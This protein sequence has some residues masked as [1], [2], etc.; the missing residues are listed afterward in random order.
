MVTGS[1]SEASRL[2]QAMVTGSVLAPNDR[3]TGSLCA[4]PIRFQ[5]NVI[6]RND[7]GVISCWP[8]AKASDEY[9][10]ENQIING[11]LGA[12]RINRSADG[13][14]ALPEA[15]FRGALLSSSRERWS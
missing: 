5:I 7:R 12:K 3:V 15:A 1:K 6:Q 8:R 4:L 14:V 10:T 9:P 2:L 13:P 11:G